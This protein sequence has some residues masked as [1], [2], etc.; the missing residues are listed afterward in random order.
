MNRPRVPKFYQNLFRTLCR[1]ELYEEL[2]GDLEET[3][4]ENVSLLGR[5]EASRIY[6]K[7][8]IRLIR[9]SVLKNY[10]L[11]ASTD[12]FMIGN[13]TKIALRNLARDKEHS[14]ISIIGLGAGLLA[15]ILIFQY[16]NFETSYDGF[17]DQSLGKIYRVSR[18]N[19][20]IETGERI[21]QNSDTF[22][23]LK[24]AID[25]DIPEVLASTQVTGSFLNFGFKGKIY[26]QQAA[27]FTDAGFFK[28]FNIPLLKGNPKSLNEPNQVFVS[29]S[30]AKTVFGDLD[31]VGQTLMYYFNDIRSPLLVSGVFEDMPQ[32]THLQADA[33]VSMHRATTDALE[34]RWFGDLTY[35]Q[36]KWRWSNFH[37]YVRVIPGADKGQVQSKIDEVIARNRGDR[38]VAAG[39]R[40]ASVLH[41]I[42]D[43]HF[44][45]NFRNQIGPSNSRQVITIFKITGVL[46]VLLAWINFV[47]LTSARAVKRAKEIGI[48][49][50]MGAAKHQ[51][52]TQFLLESLIL[53]M[54]ALSLAA[55][56][57]IVITPIFHATIGMAV[58]DYLPQFVNFWIAFL[59]A[60]ILGA[61]LSGT[62]PAL[63]LTRFQPVAVLHGKFG[64]SKHGKL[65]R[66]GLLFIQ[67]VVVLV[68]LS[69]VLVIKAQ[70]QHM[71]DY[72]IGMKTE[73][74][75]TLEMP[76]G[77]MRDTTFY[78]KLESFEE[79]VKSWS[80]VQDVTVATLIPGINNWGGQAVQMTGK[81][82]QGSVFMYRNTVDENFIAF[83]K[84][85][86]LAGRDFDEKLQGDEHAIIVNRKLV[87][88]FGASPE[89]AV[90]QNIL[91]Q[92]GADPS[93][94]IGVVED[95]YP[96]GIKFPIEP[97]IISLNGSDE[98]YF[99][100]IRMRSE[101]IRS[102]I[103]S[104]QTGFESF[105]PGAPFNFEFANQRFQA[106]YEGDRQ[107]QTVLRFFS[108]I[109]IIISGLGILG[110]SS[111]LINQKLKE[112][113]IRKVLGATYLQ[114]VRIFT[115]DYGVLIVSSALCGLPLA[116]W[117]TRSW[118]ENFTERIQLNLW[119]FTLPLVALG[120]IVGLIV[121]AKTIKA[122]LANP[123]DIL[124]NE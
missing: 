42:E 121:A 77:Y 54:V 81:T 83:H 18:I 60:F 116:F 119:Y 58:F 76:P 103:S 32:N 74:I 27:Y 7:E 104:L 48:R 84:M 90:G 55:V 124:R 69:G 39:R 106:I 9:P 87:E 44:V 101:E 97:M 89:E 78:T 33:L 28:L 20:S 49:K 6:R 96:M 110:L 92:G 112:V 115:K 30:F 98:R 65:L 108:V 86:L 34:A 26:N 64:Y 12:F 3:F 63:V 75:A 68:I 47:N 41:A 37:T 100:N 4:A 80:G 52:I 57:I 105:F 38:D 113:S 19:T 71:L 25:A 10:S 17:H 29:S 99:L 79:E 43:L 88:A 70:V 53:N 15:A 1:D 72:D 62:Y 91:F 85:Q 107:F 67:F 95:F 122:T 5:K 13:Y 50:V 23:G 120:L 82:E 11:A 111:F 22:L 66:S 118:L 114:I 35:E 14:F 46:V 117:F 123:S 56:V 51:L 31:P 59:V 21:R 93:K 40:N 16:V 109:A 36:F 2:A 8:V 24:K 73:S 94:I 102:T 45:Q 61:L